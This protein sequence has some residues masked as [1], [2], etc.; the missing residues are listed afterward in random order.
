MFILYPSPKLFFKNKE[1]PI[2]LNLPSLI[3]TILSD[4]ASASYISWVVKITDLPFLKFL[5][6]YHTPLLVLGS[7]FIY[8]IKIKYY[9]ILYIYIIYNIFTPVVGSSIK[10]ILG[11]P[12]A[13]IASDILLFI[14]PD[15]VFMGEFFI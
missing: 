13:E 10:I 15:K 5:I 3:T 2:H 14:P 11:F 8:L 1:V 12:I 6:I 9:N 7:I 4:K